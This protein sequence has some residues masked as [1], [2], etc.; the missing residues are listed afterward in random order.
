MADHG[1]AGSMWTLNGVRGRAGGWIL[2]VIVGLSAAA[3]V[4]ACAP[5][6]AVS[7]GGAGAPPAATPRTGVSPAWQAAASQAAG[8][9]AAGSEGAPAGLHQGSGAPPGA[10]SSLEALMPRF[11]GGVHLGVTSCAGPCHGR[12]SASGVI[13]GTAVRGSELSA[14]QDPFSPRGAHA[15]AFDSLRSPLGRTIA[16]NL[17]IRDPAAAAV[18]LSCHSDLAAR[19]GPELQLSDGVGCEACHGGSGA[20]WIASHYASDAD[21]TR[22]VSAGLY[23]TADL[24]ARAR[25]CLGCHLGAT[26]D[27]QF[28]THQIM[29]AGHPRM[30]FE[31]EL[32]STLQAHHVEDSRYFSDKPRQAR[33]KVWAVGQAVAASETL[34]L[35]LERGLVGG[36]F[37][38]I[39]FYDCHSCHRPITDHPDEALRPVW[40]PNPG[41]PNGPGVVAF[42]DAHL[43][44]LAGAVRAF[45][46]AHAPALSEHT[47]ALHRAL[48]TGREEAR[49]AARTLLA[50]VRRAT[51]ALERADY[52]AA[53]VE[54]ALRLI[55]SDALAP[56]FT[57]YA[58]AEQAVMAV[59]SLQRTLVDF[60]VLPASGAGPLKVAIEG[61]Y[62]AV[63]DPNRYDPGVFRARLRAVARALGV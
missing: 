48:L 43:I 8:S 29:G 6:S 24:Q 18:C 32:F 58:G 10:R 47:F 31:L 1:G 2:S 23:P 11:D 21:Y 15:R 60:G 55:M 19:R 50:T 51:S 37:P 16:S 57:G 61:A 22:N 56:R 17:G 36:M 42:N 7:P 52:N 41:R 45:A 59:D 13:E 25:L 38:E 4:S 12:Q 53:S 9:G 49:A 28:V 26:A 34:E 33:A 27:D 44:V 54:A 40:T 30:S 20:R 5:A 46:P 3:L 39:V 63:E 62:A 14:W 35:F